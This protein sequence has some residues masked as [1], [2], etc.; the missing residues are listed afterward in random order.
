MPGKGGRGDDVALEI[1]TKLE[2]SMYR[3][4]F[5]H[6]HAGAQSGGGGG[7]RWSCM[8][9]GRAHEKGGSSG[10]DGDP[11]AYDSIPAGDRGQ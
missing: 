4:G 2:E 3:A 5:G 10:T 6:G 11:P 9:M 1:A 7:A 8:A